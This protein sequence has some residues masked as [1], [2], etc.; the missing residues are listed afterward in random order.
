[1][2]PTVPFEHMG[3]SFDPSTAVPADHPMVA[4]RPDLFTPDKPK[5]SKKSAKETT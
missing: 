5:P 3:E 2:Y 4:L 1:M